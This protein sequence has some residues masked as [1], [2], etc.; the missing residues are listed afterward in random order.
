VTDHDD[1]TQLLIALEEAWNAADAAAYGRLF[2]SDAI[3]VTRSGL[4]WRGRPAI[5][6]GHAKA[7]AGALAD[8][9][10]TLQPIHISFPA[11]FLAIAHLNVEVGS[12]ETEVLRAITTLVLASDEERW[13]ILAAHTS[14]IT[15]VH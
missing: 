2:A 15:S 4:V 14:E 9:T 7:F 13:S 6:E 8:T 3:Y 5:E 10:L 1:I 12:D 11:P